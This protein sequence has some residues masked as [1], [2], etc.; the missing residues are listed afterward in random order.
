MC[1]YTCAC[2]FVSCVCVHVYMY[3]EVVC[4]CVLVCVLLCWGASMEARDNLRES[5]IFSHHEGPRIQT[6]IMRFDSK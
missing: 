2:V 6:Q 5:L 4:L 1:M 3:R